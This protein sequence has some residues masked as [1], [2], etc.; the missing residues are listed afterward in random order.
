MLKKSQIFLLLSFA[1]F[2]AG[3]IIFALALFLRIM[4]PKTAGAVGAVL[5]IL[6]IPLALL[7]LYFKNKEVT[8]EKQAEL[9]RLEKKKKKHLN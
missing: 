6:F 8:A 2:M 4:D 1:S 3:A 9:E 5:V 7:A